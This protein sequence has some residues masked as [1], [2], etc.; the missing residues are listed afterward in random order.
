MAIVG[1]ARASSSG[2]KL[3]VQLGQLQEAGCE[4]VF[5]EK[6]S[7]RATDGRQSLADML[8]WVRDGDVV[9][10][11]RL[12]RLARSVS[13]LRG[14][15]DRLEAKGVGFKC[16]QQPIDTTNASGRLM[17]NMLAAFAEFETDLRKERQR[18][19]IDKAKA[20]GD[21]YK[22]RP[23]TIDE[24]AIRELADQGLQKTEIAKRLG[25]N[26]ASVYRALA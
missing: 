19:G 18:E 20:K 24:A 14:I 4:K 12:D 25:I 21:V 10:I 9:V 23:K 13:D 11:T 1:Y 7:G 26:R 16:I 15:V 6:A 5:S 2:Q 3:D 22:G 8:E 17:L